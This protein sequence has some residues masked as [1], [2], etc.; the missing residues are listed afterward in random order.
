MQGVSYKAPLQLDL[1]YKMEGQFPSIVRKS[2]GLMPIM[3]KS[4]QCYLRHLTR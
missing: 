3:V 4:K 2:M 1:C